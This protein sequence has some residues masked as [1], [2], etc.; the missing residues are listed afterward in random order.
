[1][2]P[3]TKKQQ[4]QQKEESRRKP[5]G[6]LYLVAFDAPGPYSQPLA[7][8]MKKPRHTSTSVTAAQI[9]QDWFRTMSVEV[10]DYYSATK[11]RLFNIRTH[12]IPSP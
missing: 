12:A 6:F 1:M 9:I 10:E 2:P 8:E 4:K 5:D 7:A 11:V 3:L